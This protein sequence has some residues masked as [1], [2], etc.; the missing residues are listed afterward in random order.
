MREGS[1]CPV[2]KI[3][4]LWGISISACGKL[5]VL[6]GFVFREEDMIPK[7]C[8]KCSLWPCSNGSLGITSPV[9]TS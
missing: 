8:H 2:V 5:M 3:R 1:D 7:R 9:G 6:I 4:R